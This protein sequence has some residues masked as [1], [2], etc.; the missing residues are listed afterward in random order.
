MLVLVSYQV[1]RRLQLRRRDARE[2]QRVMTEERAANKLRDALVVGAA[3]TLTRDVHDLDKLI[4][5]L[6]P[7]KA[8]EFVAKGQERLHRMMAKL[9]IA[10]RLR[11]E[12]PKHTFK[13]VKL[14]NLITTASHDFIATTTQRGITL[15]FDAD[16][17][18]HIPNPELITFTLASLLDNAIA[19]SPDHGKIEVGA[20]TGP[21]W[22]TLTV[23]DYGSGIPAA[24]LPVLF[25]PFS[26]AE[27]AEV[28]SHEGMGFNLYLD[29]LIM[30]YLG[31]TI[32]LESAPGSGTTV[33]LHL[34]AA[35][36]NSSTGKPT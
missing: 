34:P 27:G 28:F 24:K 36:P 6:A 4:A 30:T 3:R 26:K 8:A 18:L 31:G 33:T 13:T 12:R 9:A 29:K 14:G 10:A 2:L 21:S 1:F 20:H 15:Q 25:Q 17:P 19:Y 35:P 5:Q 23:T 32:A 7:S 16:T 11:S 22:T